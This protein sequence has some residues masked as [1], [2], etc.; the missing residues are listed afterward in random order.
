MNQQQVID[1]ILSGSPTPC[2]DLMDKISS[3]D[4]THEAVR[5]AISKHYGGRVRSVSEGARIESETMKR[6]DC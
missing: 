6:M 4:V 5:V 2:S 3:R 1:R